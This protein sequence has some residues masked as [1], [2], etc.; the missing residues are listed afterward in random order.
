ML[1]KLY[2]QFFQSTCALCDDAAQI[3]L[4]LCSACHGNLPS[5]QH[6][7]SVCALPLPP[8]EGT[9]DS[10]LQCGNCLG[11][12]GPVTQS[13]IPYLYRPPADYMIRRLKYADD[14]KFGRLTGE[15]LLQAINHRYGHLPDCLIPVPLHTS[16]YRRRGF[17]QA[18]IIA[19]HLA[20]RLQLPV[21]ESVV[22]RVIASD[23]QAALGARDR[24]RN[25]RRAFAV[26][27]SVTAQW[28][29]IVDDVYTTG[30]TCST[31]A[32]TLLAA[33]ARRVDVWA[34]ART[35]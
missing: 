31:L 30:T 5:N 14:T 23:Q 19:G 34:F 12:N 21:L 6:A 10:M 29:A 20:S 7:C 3:D 11:Q 22:E 32:S 33:G 18:G 15:L 1:H 26:K 13:V 27:Q 16:R 2:T 9:A 17:N 25:M 24:Q 4:D 35:P 8:S 28:V